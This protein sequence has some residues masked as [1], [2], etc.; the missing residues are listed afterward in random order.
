MIEI[1]L[2]KKGAAWA[3]SSELWLQPSS[4]T[5]SAYVL[6]TFSFA[7]KEEDPW[8]LGND[9]LRLLASE[10]IDAKSLAFE[11]VLD[12]LS[13]H[14]DPNVIDPMELRGC[15]RFLA[16]EGCLEGVVYPHSLQHSDLSILL[17]GLASPVRLS[18]VQLLLSDNDPR[19]SLGIATDIGMPRVTTH[20]HLRILARA[21]LVRRVRTDHQVYYEVSRVALHFLAA[22]I[23]DMA[24]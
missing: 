7:L 22:L 1:A 9:L 13:S 21:N 15:L 16:L 12:A 5:K 20:Y 23:Q 19:T 14:V 18:I 17:R 24:T 8:T 11:H 3:A 2:T 10:P 4:V 6:G